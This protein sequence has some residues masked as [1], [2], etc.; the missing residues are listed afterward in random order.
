MKSK[1]IISSGGNKHLASAF[2]TTLTS[3]GMKSRNST[4]DLK[5]LESSECYFT[6]SM[7]GSNKK[8]SVSVKAPEAVDHTLPKDWDGAIKAIEGMKPEV[9]KVPKPD[10]KA[11]DIVIVDKGPEDFEHPGD[12]FETKSVHYV[13]ET[14][15]SAINSCGLWLHLGTS[16]RGNTIDAARCRKLTDYEITQTVLEKVFSIGTYMFVVNPKLTGSLNLKGKVYKI[17]KF[18]GA[19]FQLDN[20]L[21]SSSWENA[22]SARLATKEEIDTLY[23]GGV[24]P[25]VAGYDMKFDKGSRTVSFGCQN[26]TVDQVKAIR[27][28]FDVPKVV[29]LSIGGTE[30]TAD[31]LDAM[32]RRTELA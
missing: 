16:G 27:R 15:E 28:L 26:F 21:H 6:V 29:R 1:I 30:V 10:F 5:N 25:E 18:S 13:F 14:E 20:P 9:K 8:V 2:Y 31:M 23:V 19:H 32:V 4:R 24:C 7:D 17:A 11:G 3:M 12:D 22:E